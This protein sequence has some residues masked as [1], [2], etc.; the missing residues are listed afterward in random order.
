ME[1]KS[2]YSL[3]I[4]EIDTQHKTLLELIA[5]FEHAVAEDAHWNT[6]QPLIARTREFVKFHFAVEESLM[7]IVG[8]PGYSAHRT[9][10]Q[11]VLEQLA[12]LEHRVLRQETKGELKRMMRSWLFRHIID[13]DQPFARYALD[14]FPRLKCAGLK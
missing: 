1:W 2:E 12:A 9:E 4:E 7:Q 5:A 8:Y 3:G 11:A 14:Q 10:H 13:S 6:V